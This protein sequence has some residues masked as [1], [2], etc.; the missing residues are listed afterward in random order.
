MDDALN[1]SPHELTFTWWGCCSYVFH[2]NQPSLLTPFYSV[3]VSISVFVALSTVFHSINSPDNSSLSHSVLLVWFLP[4]LVLSTTYLSLS[5]DESHLQSWYNPSWL[6]GLKAPTNLLTFNFTCHSFLNSHIFVHYRNVMKQNSQCH[7]S[8]WQQ[9]YH[10]APG[11]Y[12]Q[13]DSECFWNPVNG[14]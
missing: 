13:V 8:F 4:S 3:L 14:G 2:T 12:H 9:P 5:L 6:T 1:F 11:V 10:A 7:S